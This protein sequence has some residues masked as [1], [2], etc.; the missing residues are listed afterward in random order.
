MTGQIHYDYSK[1][2]LVMILVFACAAFGA[3]LC[4]LGFAPHDKPDLVQKTN[5]KIDYTVKLKP[6][7]YFD[8]D[9]LPS[10]GKYIANL[11]DHFNIEYANDIAFSSPVSGDYSY[12]IIATISA[13]E[14]K[15]ANSVSYWSR[16]YELFKSDKITVSN[17]QKINFSR[18]IRV[19]YD[20]YNE[21]LRKFKKQY[22]LIANGRLKISLILT[23]D[24]KSENVTKD[25]PLKSSMDMSVQLTQQAVEVKIDTDADN[26]EIVL[27]SAQKLD[28]DML[29]VSRIA[30][31]VLIVVALIAGYTSRYVGKIKEASAEFDDNVRKLLSA[32][33][34]IIVDLKFAP[35][36]SGI[37]TSEVNDF[38]ELLDVY[39]SVHMPIN[40]YS[41]KNTSTFVIVDGK[42]AW[43][44][45]IRLSDYK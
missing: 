40:H 8:K 17:V 42:M 37:K 45:V 19:K 13:D 22:A 9:T 24:L 3:F 11:I 6:N 28:E 38:D 10:G 36:L 4:I 41:G 20:T 16:D 31:M 26:S 43:K 1:R 14:S 29:L 12:R 5:N 33:D 44:Y 7:E 35:N 34:S 2:I 39:N 21:M 25:I 18:S 23:G 15:G 30:G 32:Y 27:A